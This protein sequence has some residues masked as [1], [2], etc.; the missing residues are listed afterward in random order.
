MEKMYD[1]FAD[2]Y[3]EVHKDYIQDIPLWTE[4]ARKCGSPVLELACGTGRVLITLAKEGF[5][6]TGLDSNESMLKKAK[7]KIKKV[8][9]EVQ[10]RIKLI[11]SDMTNF[12]L[13]DKFNL[14]SIVF[15]SFQHLLNI[16]EQ[17]N[18]LKAIHRHLKDKGRL[19]I[20]VFYPDLT[21]PEGV[22]RK[23]DYK[24]IQ[25]FPEKDDKTELFCYQY[26]N[27][28]K[29]ETDVSYLLD[30]QK[31]NG[32][33]LRKKMGFTIHYFFP[34]EFERMLISNG[35]VV[36]DLFGDY[37][38]SEFTRRSPFMIFVAKKG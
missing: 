31:P 18:C 33:L 9:E 23:E 1:I 12:Q 24:L 21:R 16:Q 29:Q 34:I 19:I 32:Q 10:N 37:D 2:F 13:K 36:E 22:I 4:Y 26:F 8:P 7:E 30:T 27:H 20:S 25:D 17:D 15:N 11:K 28:K 38:K 14:A 35:F 5:E 6:V 3:D